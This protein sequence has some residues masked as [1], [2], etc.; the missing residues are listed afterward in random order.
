MSI[1]VTAAMAERPSGKSFWQS[2]EDLF[3]KLQQPERVRDRA[4]IF[5][6]PLPELLLRPTEVGEKVPVTLR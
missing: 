6:D 5:A 2:V 4:S 1:A 3:G